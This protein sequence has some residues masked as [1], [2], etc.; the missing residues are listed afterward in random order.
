[1]NAPRDYK[2]YVSDE[3]W[4]RTYS[5]YQKKYAASPR[6]SDK[7]LVRILAREIHGTVRTRR[8]ARILDI[9]C[10]TGNL[11]RLIKDEIPGAELVGGDLMAPVVE[12]CRRA[13]D[14]Q[15]IQ[16]DVMDIFD[17]P[18]GRQFDA[19]IAN[20]VSVYFEPDEYVRALKSVYR[21]LSPAGV[22]IAYEWVFPGAREE[23]IVEK[24]RSHP[25]GLKFWFRSEKFVLS[26]LEQTGFIDGEVIPF[27]IPIDLP[28]PQGDEDP[29]QTYT[30]LH[31]VTNRRL[32]YRGD[33][34]QPWSHIVARRY[35]LGVVT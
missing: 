17:I 29:H 9:G 8:P 16:F 31:P 30:K 5:D 12:E 21:A 10:S 18:T 6:E 26:A 23:R 27:E 14:L 1:M 19:I 4:A 7:K 24:S 25:D 11:L 20:A 35:R 22:F 28:P 2:N 3:T 32:M 15:G 33:L 13:D 34:Y